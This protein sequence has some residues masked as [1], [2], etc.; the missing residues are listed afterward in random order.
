M[1]GWCESVEVEKKRREEKEE[2]E[3]VRRKSANKKME[4]GE[5]RKGWEKEL[6]RANKAEVAV[7]VLFA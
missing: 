6:S 7:L 2:R 5:S 3:R 1:A 4:E